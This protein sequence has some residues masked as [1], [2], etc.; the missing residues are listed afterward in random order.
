VTEVYADMALNPGY[1]TLDLAW[2]DRAILTYDP[3]AA[4]AGGKQVYYEFPLYGPDDGSPAY[5]FDGGTIPNSVNGGMRWDTVSNQGPAF[6]DLNGAMQLRITAGGVAIPNHLDILGDGPPVAPPAGYSR[7]YGV[8][9]HNHDRLEVM[10]RDGT[11]IRLARDVLITAK[12]V[13]GVQVDKGQMVYINGAVG[14]SDAPTVALAQANT[15]ATAN[16][17]FVAMEDTAH[18][19]FGSFMKIGSLR[20]IDTLTPGWS[21][22]DRLFLDFAVAGGLTNVEPETPYPVVFAGVVVAQHA[23]NGSI[24]FNIGTRI[25]PYKPGLYPTPAGR[26]ALTADVNDLALIAYP[27]PAV[28]FYIDPDADG[29]VIN[30]IVS[31]A[32]TRLIRLTNVDAVFGF[33]IADEGTGTAANRVITGQGGPVTVPP[34]ATAILVYDVADSRWRLDTVASGAAGGFPEAIGYMGW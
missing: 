9:E 18:N 27:T 7:V 21:E 1:A 19:D 24:Q 31:D 26:V 32:K 13:A 15:D 12:N 20:G 5:A 34:L 22:G 2:P 14:A 4:V 30:S 17:V 23:I 28:Q 29:W 3:D 25:N 6:F 33:V 10:D 16:G 8:D 11:Q